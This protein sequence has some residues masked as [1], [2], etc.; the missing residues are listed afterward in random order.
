MK[1]TEESVKPVSYDTR[2]PSNRELNEI[3]QYFSKELNSQPMLYFY[4]QSLSNN[5][6]I[7]Q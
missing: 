1:K 5:T 6:P 2:I 3:K 4:L 7:D